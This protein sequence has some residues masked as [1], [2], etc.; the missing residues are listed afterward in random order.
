MNSNTGYVRAARDSDIPIIEAWLPKDESVPSLAVN[1]KL[2]KKVYQERGMLV[3]EDATTEIPVAYFWGSLHSHDSVLEI[4]PVYRRRGIGRAF[5]EHLI[6]RS[7]E[8]GEPLLEIECA[9]E[10][11]K[12]FWMAMGFDVRE[13]GWSMYGP[14]LIGQKILR[15]PRELPEGPQ[16]PVTVAFLPESA[17]YD[18]SIVTPLVKHALVGAVGR[19]GGI[20]L[21]ERVAYFD[22]DDGKDL[23]IEIVVAG[24]RVYRGKA[25][26]QGAKAIGVAPCKRGFAVD[27]LYF[28]RD[29]LGS[30]IDE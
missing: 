5:V 13:H 18:D 3:W 21:N 9:P 4:H 6:D 1:W 16:I 30:F 11:S 28:G 22:L 19:S 27:T 7:R 14:Q 23:V 12:E 15:L 29:A 25:K 10:T 17:A 8:Q 20:A 2:T 24:K 26:H